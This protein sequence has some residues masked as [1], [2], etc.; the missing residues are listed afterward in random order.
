MGVAITVIEIAAHCL[1]HGHI[2]KGK[3]GNTKKGKLKK[4]KLGY[5][6]NVKWFLVRIIM[7]ENNRFSS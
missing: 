3:K 6:N 5:R 1:W 2:D 7:H 4:K